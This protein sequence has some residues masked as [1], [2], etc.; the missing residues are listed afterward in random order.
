MN[1]IK[2]NKSIFD[3][4][5]NYYN[6]LNL[7]KLN[8]I[9][10]KFYKYKTLFFKN[11]KKKKKKPYRWSYSYKVQAKFFKKL[12]RKKFK[13]RKIQFKIDGFEWFFKKPK[14][15]KKKTFFLKIRT[16]LFIKRTYFRIFKLRSYYRKLYKRRYRR[17][18]RYK[19]LKLYKYNNK[20]IRQ[21]IFKHKKSEKFN[22]LPDVL[23]LIDLLKSD[24]NLIK[25]D[26]LKNIFG[27]IYIKSSGINT[28]IT[29]TG[30]GGNV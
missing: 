28:F 12:K 24:F 30:A 19:I 26:K 2:I 15:K 29:I 14:L 4:K 10:I 21:F 17:F 6:I 7:S 25:M 18:K 22:F 9:K 8:K 13:K 5:T 1:L 23:E 16:Y 3:F 27:F 11:I 20:R